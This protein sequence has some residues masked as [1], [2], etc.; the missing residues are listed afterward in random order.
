MTIMTEIEGNS[1]FFICIYMT[2][3]V[4]WCPLKESLNSEGQQ[5]HQFQQSE[6]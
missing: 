6:L 1:L 2:T 5:F 3:G 4:V